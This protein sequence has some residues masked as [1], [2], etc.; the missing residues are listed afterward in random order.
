MRTVQREVLEEVA[1][2]G[3]T[4]QRAVGAA[5]VLRS[6]VL[7]VGFARYRGEES[8]PPHA[9]DEEVLYVLAADGA[10]LRAGPTADALD[11]SVRLE[12]GMVVLIDAGEWHRI[13]TEPGGAADVLYIH[14]PAP[15]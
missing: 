4:V 8:V 13:E 12:R 7:S 1:R 11:R 3:R 5:D 15:A 10:T 14:G 6:E 2:P 9:H